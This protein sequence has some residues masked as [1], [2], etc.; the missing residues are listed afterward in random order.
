MK[1]AVQCCALCGTF[2]IKK[3]SQSNTVLMYLVYLKIRTLHEK[4]K[5]TY[6]IYIMNIIVT[7]ALKYIS[8][9]IKMFTFFRTEKFT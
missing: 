7:Y 8:I 6:N 4:Q 1:E 9:L 5:C 3:I 2:E